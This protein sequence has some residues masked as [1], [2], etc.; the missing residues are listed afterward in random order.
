MRRSIAFDLVGMDR[1]HFGQVG[2]GLVH[3]RLKLAAFHL[4]E[5]AHG[6]QDF[7]NPPVYRVR[8]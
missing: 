7:G 3:Q 4:G 6:V 5:R 1:Q 2:E 8:K